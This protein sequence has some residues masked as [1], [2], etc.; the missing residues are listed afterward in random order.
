[1]K[2]PPPRTFIDLKRENYTLLVLGNF[3]DT[4]ETSTIIMM[5]TWRSKE[6]L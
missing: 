5:N 1:M 3:A 2:K 4:K 6:E